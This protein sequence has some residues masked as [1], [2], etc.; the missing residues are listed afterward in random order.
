[1]IRGVTTVEGKLTSEAR[2]DELGLQITH[3]ALLVADMREAIS[4]YSDMFG[5]RFCERHVAPFARVDHYGTSGPVEVPMT[6]SMSGPPYVE[7]LEATGDGLWSQERG[8]GVHHVGGFAADFGGTVDRCV[9]SGLEREATIF[10]GNGEPI[11]AFFAPARPDGV[12]V[13]VLSTL[14]RPSWSA[15]VA[16]GPPPGHGP[17]A[18]QGRRQ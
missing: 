5:M 4:R 16:G 13:E 1:M 15:W 2:S 11:I 10:A 7:L 6:Y 3:F 12:R 18:D 14:L 9:D 17:S 8:L